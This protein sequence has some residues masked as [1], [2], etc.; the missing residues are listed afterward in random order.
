MSKAKPRGTD[1]GAGCVM[2]YWNIA[3][4]TLLFNLAN[5]FKKMD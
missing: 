2:M 5:E 4:G 3:L 1:C